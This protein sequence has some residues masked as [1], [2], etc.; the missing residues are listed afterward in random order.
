MDK[1]LDIKTIQETTL[2]FYSHFCGINIAE[3]EL[4]THFICS[5]ERDKPLKGLG[6]K[7]TLYIFVKDGLSVVSYSPKYHDFIES[8]K[9]YSIDDILLAI[10]QEHKLKY[11]RL[12]MFHGEEVTQYGD[13]EILTA[14]DYPL[15]ETFFRTANPSSNPDGWLYEYFTEKTEKGYIA[16]YIKDGLLVSVCDAPD[17]PYM[18]DRIQHT[19]IITLKE[20]RKKGYARC[21]A[22]LSTHHLIKSGV[23]PQWECDVNNIASFEL[24][25]S[26]GYREFGLAYILKEK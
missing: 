6:C 11:M 3:L 15:Y 22:A 8:M 4:G 24:A 2:Q 16:G 12:L 26:L 9:K 19:G 18:E 14:E 5:A 7:Y 17:M 20:E 10:Q 21:A 25:K 13:A 1:Q 23:C